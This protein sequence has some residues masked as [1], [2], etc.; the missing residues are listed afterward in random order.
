MSCPPIEIGGYKYLV[1]NGTVRS[2]TKKMNNS[3][4]KFYLAL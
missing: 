2:I 4:S 1:P 3:N